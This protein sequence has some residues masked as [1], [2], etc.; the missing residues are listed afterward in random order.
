MFGYIDAKGEVAFDGYDQVRSFADGWARVLVDG[1]WGAIDTGG[2][3]VIE[4]TFQSLG[5]LDGGVAPAT[6]DGAAGYVDREGEWVVEPEYDY[7]LPFA[8]GHGVVIRGGSIPD[9]AK[10]FQTIPEGGKW[11]AIDARGDVVVDLEYGIVK[12][13][14]G[15]LLLNRKGKSTGMGFAQGGRWEYLDPASGESFGSYAEAEPFGEGLACVRKG[16]AWQIIG[17]DGKK[18]ATIQT[19]GLP[20]ASPSTFREGRCK[21]HYDGGGSDRS[22]Y[23]FIDVDGA[24]VLDD[25]GAARPFVEGWAAVN[26]GGTS[27]RGEPRGGISGWVH[28]DG[29]TLTDEA[30]QS[31]EEF[32]SGLGLVWL[33]REGVAFVDREGEVVIDG[34]SWAQPFSEGYACVRFE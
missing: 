29:D 3:W 14:D 24:V 5:D 10:A 26:M 21:L 1:K 16:R 7:T 11:G 2:D 12:S 9:Y 19:K 18:T 30:W 32:G 28:L 13:A 15:M 22:K 27:V 8:S 4:P 33:K 25:L 31:T 23:A 6:L 34:W 20:A 17:R